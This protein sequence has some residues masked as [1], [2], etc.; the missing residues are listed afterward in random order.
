L[1]HHI[2]TG[3][4]YLSRRQF[5]RYEKW[6]LEEQ[7]TYER[8]RD[9]DK[10]GQSLLAAACQLKSVD[11][12][13]R[14]WLN[15]SP[16]S[17][18]ALMARARFLHAK[19]AEARGSGTASSVSHGGWAAMHAAFMEAY[20]L[21]ARAALKVAVPT[22]ALYNIG[23]LVW[24]GGEDVTNGHR[25]PGDKD[26]YDF[27]LSLDPKSRLL[28]SNKLNMLRPE[29]GGSLEEFETY[30]KSPVHDLM[31]EKDR[32]HFKR[33]AD[34]VL[35]FYYVCFTEKPEFGFRKL[36]ETI[37]MS[38]ESP[39]NYYWRGL[40]YNMVDKSAEA[41]SDFERAVLLDKEEDVDLLDEE[42][43]AR[44]FLNEK[45]LLIEP[46]L[47]RLTELG[48]AKRFHDLARHRKYNMGDVT[49]ALEVWRKGAG[50][51]IA[52]CIYELGHAY[53]D[54]DG[55]NQDSTEAVSS[56]QRAYEAGY[57]GA[58]SRIFNIVHDGKSTLIS[59]EAAAL[60][61]LQAATE[62][63]HPWSHYRLACA[64]SD[65]GLRLDQASNI[66]FVTEELAPD[67]EP[68]RLYLEHL[69][70]AAE[71]GIG[72]AQNLLA[73]HYRT[74][75]LVECSPETAQEWLE[76]AAESDDGTSAAKVQLA[77][78]ITKGEIKDSKE[79]AFSLYKEAAENNESDAMFP[80]A[81]C[82]FNGS[83]TPP[84]KKL[85]KEWTDRGK[86]AGGTPSPQLN[87]VLDEANYKEP[88]GK[89]I[90]LHIVFGPI[91]LVWTFLVAF[92]GKRSLFG[93]VK[94][95][96]VMAAV[97]F[98]L[99]FAL[100]WFLSGRETKIPDSTAPITA[101]ANAPGEAAES[102]DKKRS[103]VEILKDKRK[104]REARQSNENKEAQVPPNVK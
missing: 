12:A 101:T 98:L 43:G 50:E 61:L 62:H 29:W 31:S 81:L 79:R 6:I 22:E 7:Q 52:R 103:F 34:C 35:G 91:A 102:K 89:S 85:A 17:Y 74:G 32:R 41:L 65:N 53:D 47:K 55:V 60:T 66:H 21:Y 9:A 86:A 23:A 13:T 77:D 2:E 99:V 20:T 59:K 54:G 92:M 5:D 95:T 56:Y 100:G 40:A 67:T 68:A 75:N 104:A 19:G 27:G 25:F 18:A 94:I 84:N 80:L 93:L 72:R 97:G 45:D 46:K 30:L 14:R 78:M 33:Y 64:I 96:L 15:Q 28:R 10:L 42:V 87:V 73:W 63:D 38:P 58:A 48:Q 39:W 71:G 3:L 88:L 70:A 24:I 36:D 49:G 69:N 37:A 4:A 44:W 76:I 8:D 90:L 51:G 26:W 16:E 11:E 82:Y 57:I 1:P 83:G